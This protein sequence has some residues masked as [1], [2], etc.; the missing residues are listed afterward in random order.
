VNRLARDLVEFAERSLAEDD[1]GHQRREL[2]AAVAE[3]QRRIESRPNDRSQGMQEM[4]RAVAQAELTL[5]RLGP[6][7]SPA[8]D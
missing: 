6:A 5:S 4:R 3:A 2:R 7:Q 8:V 1:P